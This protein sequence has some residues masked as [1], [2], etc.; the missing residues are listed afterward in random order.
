M[1]GYE[2]ETEVLENNFQDIVDS[3]D[4]ER[5]MGGS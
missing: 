1:M 3:S 2:N 4:K 5:V